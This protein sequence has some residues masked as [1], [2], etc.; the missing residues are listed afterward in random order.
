ME[1]SLQKKLEQAVWV[2]RS[3]YD[4][5]KTS[6]SSANLSLL[7]EGAVYI[8][9]SGTCFGNLS[10]ADFAC[11]ALDGKPLDQRKASKEFE[12]H[13]ALY[14]KNPAIQAVIHTHS[15][16]ATLWSCLPHLDAKNAIPPYT[17][18]LGMKLGCVALT[19]YAA[20]GSEEL[21]RLFRESLCESNGY[22]LKN[23]GPIV[24]APSMME[25]YFA[26]EELEESARI[27]WMLRNEPEREQMLI[28]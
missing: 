21:F 11:V 1:N 27:A 16:Y 28:H 20:P 8:S 14:Q 17:P 23:H 2:A 6:G 22:L 25:A 9:A 18:Y 10:V 7:H 19:P 3:L 13:R 12:L 15:T 5:G 26:L 24:G 4:R